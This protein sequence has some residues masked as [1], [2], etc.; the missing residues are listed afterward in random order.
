M[1]HP[2]ANKVWLAIFSVWVALLSGAFAHWVGSPGVLQALHLSGL[3]E[4]K[5]A[6]QIRTQDEI[7]KLQ[8]SAD[9]LEKNRAAQHREIRKV[10]GYAAAD[11]LIF[12][13]NKPDAL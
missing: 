10:L 7:A 9:L 13:F 3:L 1:P 5:L 11:E 4:T 8:T 2:I 6:L 12:D